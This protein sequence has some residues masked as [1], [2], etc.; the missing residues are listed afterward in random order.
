MKPLIGDWV[1]KNNRLP[2]KAG[3]YYCRMQESTTDGH[4]WKI[5][6][7]YYDGNTFAEIMNE[8]EWLAENKKNVG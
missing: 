7:V 1:N 2:D 8:F 6:I 3:E 4:I 5:F